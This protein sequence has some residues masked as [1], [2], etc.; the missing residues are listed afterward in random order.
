MRDEL[1][2]I[3]TSD[4]EALLEIR[5]EETLLQGLIEKAKASKGNVPDAVFARV[6]RDYEGRLLATEAK[7]R[8]LRLTARAELSKLTTLH[9][10]LKQSLDAA[11]LDQSELQFRHEIGELTDDEF[12]KRKKNAEG[13]LATSQKDFDGADKLRQRFLEVLPPEPEPK[14]EARPAASPRPPALAASATMAIPLVRA[15]AALVG[16][17]GP[18]FGTIVIPK[19]EADAG[20]SGV[21]PDFGTIVIPTARLIAT[22][23]DGSSGR[24][25]PLG[26][27]ATI[28][29]TPENEIAI[30]LPEVSRRHAQ[31]T[32]VDG[33]FTIK[34]LG[35]NNG[36]FV[37]GKRLAEARL[38]D[39]DQVQVG[40]A[41]FVFRDK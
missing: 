25:Y 9:T 29:R 2:D 41:V 1:R 27:L 22:E 6:L 7:A 40:P 33:G 16:A 4:V 30:E 11:Q 12:Q 26:M 23:E 35:S 5:K 31:L 13:T 21:S 38:E 19:E 36:T 24:A 3:Q 10:R 28:G 39:W 37:N 14:P 15:P 32:F 20:V 17:P 34:D 18:D 8:P